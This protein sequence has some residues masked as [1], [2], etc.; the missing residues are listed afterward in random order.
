VYWQLGKGEPLGNEPMSDEGLIALV[1]VCILLW[2]IVLWIMLAVRLNTYVDPE[3]IHYKYF[4]K[5]KILIRPREIASVEIHRKKSIYEFFQPGFHRHDT[6]RNVTT[7][8]ISGGNHI[9]LTFTNKRRLLLGTQRPDE[10]E[11]AIKRLMT[12][13]LIN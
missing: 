13:D 4:N 11:R 5:P 6:F 7:V 10:F 8:I 3:G 12:S 9:K 1:V 2:L